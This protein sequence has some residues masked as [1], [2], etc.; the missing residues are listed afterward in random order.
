M[1][2]RYNSDI[3]ESHLGTTWSMDYCF[4]SPDDIEEDMHAILLC[5]DHTKMG[6]WAL[7]VDRKGADENVV[8]WVVDK[9]ED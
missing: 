7:A 1:Q 4:M 5:Y 8:K 2:H 9:M 6:M 3:D